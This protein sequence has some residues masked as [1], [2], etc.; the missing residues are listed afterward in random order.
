MSERVGS[1][2]VDLTL[3][4]LS[5]AAGARLNAVSRVPPS[6]STTEAMD[7]RESR[8]GGAQKCAHLLAQTQ[9]QRAIEACE[10]QGQQ[11]GTWLGTADNCARTR[12]QQG[13]GMPRSTSARIRLA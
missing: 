6:P 2:D 3:I 13:A 8:H 12:V 4:A 11:Q 1:M 10:V 7:M 5:V 9:H